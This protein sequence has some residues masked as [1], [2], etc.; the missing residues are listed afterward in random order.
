MGKKNNKYQAKLDSK[1]EN[2]V[3][4]ESIEVKK[5]VALK[6]TKVL[7][8]KEFQLIEGEEIP[9]ELNEAFIDSLINSNLIK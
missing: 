6:T 5:Y 8:N 2:T 7:C 4:S 1:E 3:L 9:K